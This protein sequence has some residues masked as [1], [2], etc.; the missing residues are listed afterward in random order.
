MVY[1]R[2]A[3]WSNKRDRVASRVV[4][5]RWEVDSDRGAMM[6]SERGRGT[7]SGQEHTGGIGNDI[8]G[9]GRLTQSWVR[10]FPTTPIFRQRPLVSNPWSHCASVSVGSELAPATVVGGSHDRE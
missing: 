2:F 7:G 5:G 1:P 10:N 8:D 4:V 6:G 9:F 3:S